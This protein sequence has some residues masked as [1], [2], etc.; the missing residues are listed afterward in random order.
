MASGSRGIIRSHWKVTGTKLSEGRLRQWISICNITEPEVR[1]GVD[2]VE[3]PGLNSCPRWGPCSST[4]STNWTVSP[5]SASQKGC[6]LCHWQADPF[7]QE[8][9][10]QPENPSSPPHCHS[11]VRGA[12]R[13]GQSHQQLLAATSPRQLLWKS[14][15][16]LS[17]LSS[18]KLLVMILLTVEARVELA[19]TPLTW[20]E[21]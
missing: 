7:S 8:L 2:T 21:S 12:R 17:S 10:W 11:S 6:S 18:L 9:C 5:R 19:A 14:Q 1:L 15:Q 16:K 3:I 20:L 13:K 4:L